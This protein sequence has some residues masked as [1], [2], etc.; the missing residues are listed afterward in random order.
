MWNANGELVS[1]GFPKFFNGGEQTAITP[2]PTSMYG[3]RAFEKLDGSLFI[4]SKYKGQLIVRTRGTS[5]VEDLPS[6]H[7]LLIFQEKYPKVFDNYLLNTEKVTMLY[8]WTSP[9]NRI[10]ITYDREPELKL[11]GM[12]HH[13]DYSLATQIVLN[14]EAFLLGVGRPKEY[15]FKT[16]EELAE[17]A[18]TLVGEEGYCLYS[19]KDQVITKYKS[20]WYLAMHRMKSPLATMDELLESF[21]V[22]ALPTYS[23]FM[24]AIETIHDYEIMLTC[25]SNASKLYEAKKEVDKI[26]AHMKMF[27]DSVRGMSRRDAALQI[28][29]AYGKTNRAGYVFAFLDNATLKNEAVKK[30][31]Y[32]VMKK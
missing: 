17:T 21:L 30:L 11:V 23:E 15:F 4:V 6:G 5:T 9:E 2:A 26:M 7:E 32:Q 31:Y 16:V 13:Q 27:A 18:R 8:E 12:I 29:D 19:N 28:Q 10:V 3:C 25:R 22:L 14:H 24:T 20:E 1:A